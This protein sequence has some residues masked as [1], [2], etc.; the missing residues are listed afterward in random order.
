MFLNQSFELKSASLAYTCV[1][2]KVSDLNQFEKDFVHASQQAP[3]LFR[4]AAFIVEFLFDDLVP[5]IKLKRIRK[6]IESVGA[7]LVG[8]KSNAQAQMT[9]CDKAYVAIIHDNKSAIGSAPVKKANK[10]LECPRG[11]MVQGKIRS[12][13]QIYAK[14]KDL[15]V[16][17]DVSH[18][19]EI[20]ASGNVFIYGALFG[21]AIAGA[22]GDSHSEIFCHQFAPEL[23][24]IAGIYIVSED[25]GPEFQQKSVRARMINDKITL[26][27]FTTHQGAKQYTL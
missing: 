20:I 3:K 17:G 14:D 27:S 5:S 8:V 6:A 12:G 9:E 19:S 15:V 16:C 4:N 11:L 26:S 22:D 24:S 2:I 10:I 25:I 13:T 21:K 23:I 18:G 1:R 7:S